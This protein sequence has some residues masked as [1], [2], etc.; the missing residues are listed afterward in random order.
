MYHA[1]GEA[2]AARLLAKTRPEGENGEGDLK[3][4]AGTPA[5]TPTPTPKGAKAPTPTP[6][7]AK[8]PA[9][10]PTPTPAAKRPGLGLLGL[11]A[12]G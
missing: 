5:P 7:G 8:P 6:T 3:P 1:T 12:G 10:A 9:P 2:R 4:A 11:L